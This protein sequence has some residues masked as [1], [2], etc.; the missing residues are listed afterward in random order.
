MFDATGTFAVPAQV[1]ERH[2][3]HKNTALTQVVERFCALWIGA[4]IHHANSP[5]PAD[6]FSHAL[7]RFLLFQQIRSASPQARY[8]P[9]FQASSCESGCGADDLPRLMPHSLN[10]P[11]RGQAGNRVGKKA[12]LTLVDCANAST[13]HS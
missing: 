7:L 11:G 6:A 3:E 4:M 12:T 10:D 9:V 1:V 13:V 5:V 2:I 8:G